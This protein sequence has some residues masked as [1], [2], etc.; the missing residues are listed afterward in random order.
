MTYRV[1]VNGARGKMGQL[2]VATLEKQPQ[3][4]LVG[5]L[6]RE[7]DLRRAIADL[8]ADIVVELTNATCVYENSLVIVEQNAHPVIG[9]SG[10]LPEQITRLQTVCATKKLGGLIVPNFSIAAVLMIRFAAMAAA[11]LPD[12]EIIEAHHP[13][14]IDA[15]S[16]TA[17]KTAEMIASA[18]DFKKNQSAQH[19]EKKEVRGKL[20]HEVPIHAI[21]ISGVLAR[22]QVLFG[23]IG[24]TLSITH[25]SIDRVS[26]MPGLI[27]ACERVSGLDGLYY[28][29]EHVL[30]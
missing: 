29:L 12:V 24:E 10:L 2:A 27:R 21:R 16:G 17:L 5:T 23:S 6:G 3:F 7:D 28:G 11:Y 19:E 26:F 25:E 1:L 8:Q 15:P 13:Q 22:Q 9:A 30:E 18:R 20:Y 4:E 14:K